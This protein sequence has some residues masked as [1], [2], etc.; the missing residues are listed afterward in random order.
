MVEKRESQSEGK[1]GK[2]GCPGKESHLQFCSSFGGGAHTGPSVYASCSTN[3]SSLPARINLA[4][5]RARSR[6]RPAGR[7]NSM[8]LRLF[9][10]N[11]SS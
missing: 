4:V 3:A 5:I 1:R 11:R 7:H 9:G 10:K 2:R 8:R 6:V